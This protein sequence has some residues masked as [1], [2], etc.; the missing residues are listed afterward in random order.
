MGTTLG[1]DLV[2]KNLD[3]LS[4]SMDT[5]GEKYPLNIFADDHRFFGA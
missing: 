1:S 5:D 4:Q 3:I 2:E